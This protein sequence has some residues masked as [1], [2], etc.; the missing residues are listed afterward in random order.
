MKALATLP[1]MK[2]TTLPGRLAFY[3]EYPGETAAAVT[4]FL[5]AG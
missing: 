3:D 2:S 5:D 4:A 1:A